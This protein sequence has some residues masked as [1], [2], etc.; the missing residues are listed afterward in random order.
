[1]F[2]DA[3]QAAKAQSNA[4]AKPSTTGFDGK[5]VLVDGKPV[6]VKFTKQ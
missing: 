4:V 5:P 6:F 3:K 1:M 2:T